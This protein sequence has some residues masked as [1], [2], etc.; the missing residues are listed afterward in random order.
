MIQPKGICKG[1]RYTRMSKR[2]DLSD[3]D[4]ICLMKQALSKSKIARCGKCEGAGEIGG[5]A[6]FFAVNC[7]VCYGCGKIL[8]YPEFVSKPDTKWPDTK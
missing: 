4:V 7:D 5:S 1:V 6:G 2:T 8:E 3:H